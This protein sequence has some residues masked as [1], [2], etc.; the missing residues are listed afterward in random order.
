MGKIKEI[1]EGWANYILGREEEVSKLR[2]KICNECEHHSKHHSTNRPDVHCFLCKC[3]LA[4]KTRSLDSECPIK[5]WSKVK[6]DEKQEVRDK[7][8]SIE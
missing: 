6:K 3:P 4:T 8:S 1:S 7:K 5:K 2:M